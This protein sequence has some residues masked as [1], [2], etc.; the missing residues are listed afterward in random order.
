MK[1]KSLEEVF[2]IIKNDKIEMIDLRIA[3]L[4]S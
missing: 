3:Y 1:S 2:E 4:F